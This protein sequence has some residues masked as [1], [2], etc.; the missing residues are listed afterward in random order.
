MSKVDQSKTENCDTVWRMCHAKQ[1]A[2]SILSNCIIIANG[3]ATYL[4]NIVCHRYK[5]QDF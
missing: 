5:K 1:Y 4:Q 3:C 2:Q